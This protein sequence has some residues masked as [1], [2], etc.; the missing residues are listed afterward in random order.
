MTVTDPATALLDCRG[1][2]KSFAAVKALRG[3]DFSVRAGRVHGLVGENGA[4]K[5]TLT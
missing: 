5:S 3:V 4:G 2:E 1:I